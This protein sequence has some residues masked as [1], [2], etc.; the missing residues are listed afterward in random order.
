MRRRTVALVR[1]SIV[2]LRKSLAAI[3]DRWVDG[4]YTLT[5]RKGGMLGTLTI[6]GPGL[7]QPYHVLA[8]SASDARGKAPQVLAQLRQGDTPDFGVFRPL[9]LTPQTLSSSYGG[10]RL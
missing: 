9:E 7:P 3:A 5:F 4:E 6:E 10:V 1:R 8:R 2:P